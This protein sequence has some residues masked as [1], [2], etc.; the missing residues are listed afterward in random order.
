MATVATKNG[1]PEATVKLAERV[2]SVGIDKAELEKQFRAGKL[3]F[4]ELQA[5]LAGAVTLKASVNVNGVVILSGNGLRRMGLNFFPGE[6][7]ALAGIMPQLT[8]FVAEQVKAGNCSYE[9]VQRA[10]DE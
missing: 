3:S 6:L 7:R 4:D 5:A 1:K 2:L 8:K 10:I 9:R